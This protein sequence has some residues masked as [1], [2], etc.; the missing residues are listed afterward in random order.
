M[1]ICIVA[2][3]VLGLGAQLLKQP[4]ILAYLLA[5]I[6]VG[7]NV[8]KIIVNQH[9]LEVI[10]ELGLILLLFM[11]GLEIDLN[12]IL[13]S[14]KLITVT[15]AVQILGG[16]VIGAFFFWFI[17]FKF[18]G[19]NFDGL[20]LAICA[21][22]SS[23]VIIVK[24]LYDKR[25]L[26]T[27]PGRITL[28]ILVLQDIFAIM[29]LALQPNLNEST[30]KLLLASFGK[31]AVLV[32]VAFSVSRYVLPALFRAVARQPELVLAGALAWCFMIAELAQQL[33]LSRVMGALIAGVAIS[34]F[35]YTL[36]VVSKVRSLRDF[37]ITLFFVALGMMIPA[38]TYSYITWALG[39]A[40][41]VIISRFLTVFLPLHKMKA[42]HRT[43]ILPAINL[44]QISEFA[45]V[46]LTLGKQQYNHVTDQV[47]GIVGYGFVF[48]AI[49]STYAIMNSEAV[50]KWLSRWL[51]DFNVRDLD[52]HTVFLTKPEHQPKVFLLGCSWSASSLIEEIQR[53]HPAMLQEL[54]VIDFNPQVF[55][56]LRAR[57]V[58]VKYGD[59]SQRDTLINA[60]VED[61]EVIIITLPNTILKGTTNAKLVQLIR[62]V[63]PHAK[64]IAHAEFFQDLPHLYAYG[65]NFVTIPRLVEAR[66]LLDVIRA[67]QQGLLDEQ[68]AAQQAELKDRHEVIP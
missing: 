52:E 61:A 60:G 15:G 38:P 66:D 54:A 24:I 32:I 63:N 14:G 55:D 7:P 9:S 13:S 11:I 22:M 6:I 68:R 30:F 21:A 62:E 3:W 2:A 28:G 46:I 57:G 35:P 49:G 39:F 8:G 45:L 43:S 16:S 40:A 51:G 27:L 31:V 37:F 48:L 33:Q 1:A 5:G 42:G 50:M 25:E 19:A 34:T 64:V 65:A 58:Y 47:V 36:D 26:D 41:F 44:S 29:F 67:A 23:T 12:K 56:G 10:S 18:G 17:G 53:H 59:I 20:Y 4:L